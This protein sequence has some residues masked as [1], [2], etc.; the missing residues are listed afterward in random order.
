[1]QINIIITYQCHLRISLI[2]GKY[3]YP[4]TLMNLETWTGLASLGMAIMFVL[5]LFSFSNFLIGPDGKGPQRVIDAR[6]LLIQII[7]ISG[8][9][10]LI[11]TGVVFGMR[12]TD[13][14]KSSSLVVI[15]TGILLTSGT[16]IALITMVP[17]IDEQYRAEGIDLAS[18]IFIIGGVGVSGIGI[19]LLFTNKR[20][21]RR[22]LAFD[23]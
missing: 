12:K 6:A 5:L 18:R 19:Y 13:Q 2:V 16:A 21:S 9:P 3:T 4:I 11:L 10:S 20:K 22:R 14:S 17:K 1:M 7:S 23:T 15:A 8:I